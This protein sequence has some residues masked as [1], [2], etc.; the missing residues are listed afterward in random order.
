MNPKVLIV[1]LAPI[2]M[3]SAAQEAAPIQPGPESHATA[4]AAAPEYSEEGECLADLCLHD[5]KF[6]V[7]G[8]IALKRTSGRM[9]PGTDQGGILY[10]FSEDNPELLVKV[11][12][13]CDYNQH[14]WVFIGSAT[15]QEF[16]VLVKH[17]PSDETRSFRSDE[18]S[19]LLGMAKTD[20]WPCG[21]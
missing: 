16:F 4:V 12:D 11:L 7:W 17:V 3:P 19:A 18:E 10:A 6:L 20:V 21:P 5:G 15:D 13:G 8:E 1:V 2:A 9:L 14:W